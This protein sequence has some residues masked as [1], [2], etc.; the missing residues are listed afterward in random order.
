[1][2]VVLPLTSLLVLY[3][4]N[5]VFVRFLVRAA[6]A[7]AVI[8]NYVKCVPPK[9]GNYDRQRTRGRRTACRMLGSRFGEWRSGALNRCAF[10]PS[11]SLSPQIYDDPRMF[12]RRTQHTH[13][14]FYGNFVSICPAN[15]SV[16]CVLFLWIC[17]GA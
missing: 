11:L 6:A 7:A 2:K 1:M 15:C 5:F 12:T 3:G 17:G 14:F 10:F 8:Y 13:K 9:D 16:D 4:T